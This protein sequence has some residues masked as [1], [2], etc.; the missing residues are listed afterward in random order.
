MADHCETPLLAY[1]HISPILYKI[2]GRLRKQISELIVY[3]PFYCEGTVVENM[4]SLGFTSIYNRKEDFYAMQKNNTVP[5]FD[6][7]MYVLLLTI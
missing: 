7:L 2:A 3:D 1:Q 6:V 4:K 5:E